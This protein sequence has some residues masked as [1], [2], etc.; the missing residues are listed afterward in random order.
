MHLSLFVMP[1][2]GPSLGLLSHHGERTP[3][4]PCREKGICLVLL[5]IVLCLWQSFLSLLQQGSG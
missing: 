3:V 2:A 1:P 4:T 5:T